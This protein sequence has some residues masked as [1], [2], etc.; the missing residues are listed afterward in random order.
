ML[1]VARDIC[2]SPLCSV[3]NFVE[4]GKVFRRDKKSLKDLDFFLLYL[5]FQHLNCF[6]VL[7]DLSKL[8]R[9]VQNM[10]SLN[11]YRYIDALPSLVHSSVSHW[12]LSK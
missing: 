10:L 9:K 4:I 3:S 12:V 5:K 11:C 7:L 2:F 1:L 6:Q 8:F